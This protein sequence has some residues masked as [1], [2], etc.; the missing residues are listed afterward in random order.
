MKSSTTKCI[1]NFLHSIFVSSFSYL[2]NLFF[3]SL[4][5]LYYPTVSTKKIRSTIP[6]FLA[7]SLYTSFCPIYRFCYYSC[8]P[9]PSTPNSLQWSHLLCSCPWVMH[10]SYLATPFPILFLTCPCLFYNYQF[11]FFNPF[12]FSPIPQDCLPTG[13]HSNVLHF[14]DSVSVLQVCLVCFL[15]SI[16][17]SYVFVAIVIVIVHSFDPFFLE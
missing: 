17:D 10:I 8:P 9:P 15:D 14:Y 11:V 2:V 3:L 4:A 16:V 12:T 6:V 7:R 5:N 13:H 1:L